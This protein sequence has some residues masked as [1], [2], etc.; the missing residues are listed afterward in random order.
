VLPAP[1]ILAARVLAD[2]DLDR[3]PPFQS[4]ASSFKQIRL[5]LDPTFLLSFFFY[6]NVEEKCVSFA[7]GRK[8][9]L[10][11]NGMQLNA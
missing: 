3:A 7:L 10:W 4:G 5:G 6:L 2:L 1:H 8:I 9:K 11:Y